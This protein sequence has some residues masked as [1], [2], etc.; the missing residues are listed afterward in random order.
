MQEEDGIGL[1]DMLDSIGIDGV[2]VVTKKRKVTNETKCDCPMPA[3]KRIAW[4]THQSGT[5][6]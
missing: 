4:A 2:E 3:L 1:F 6:A 5:Q